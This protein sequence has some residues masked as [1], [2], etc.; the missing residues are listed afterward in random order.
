MKAIARFDEV[1]I[2]GYSLNRLSILDVKFA[3]L[4]PP[5]WTG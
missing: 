1:Y 2:A 5:I 4:A 3:N